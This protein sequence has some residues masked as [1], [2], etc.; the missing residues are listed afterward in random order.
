MPSEAV[1]TTGRRTVV[2]AAEENGKLRPVDVEV[3]M[4][5]NLHVKS[6]FPRCRPNVHAT[7]PPRLTALIVRPSALSIAGRHGTGAKPN[8]SFKTANRPLASARDCR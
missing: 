8:L 3:G 1:I 7:W 6:R 2:M 5:S 4:E